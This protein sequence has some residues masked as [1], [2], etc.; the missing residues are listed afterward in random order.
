MDKIKARRLAFRLLVALFMLAGV[1]VALAEVSTDQADYSPGSVVTISGS[2]ADGAGYLPG[3]I[4]DVSVTGPDGVWTA[5]CSALVADDGSWSCQIT[6]SS[7]LAIAVGAYTYTAAGET[8]GT[9][10]YGTF[11]DKPQCN[12]S[13]PTVVSLTTPVAGEIDVS[14]TASTADYGT[15]TYRV[16]YINGGTTIT[17]EPVAG[18]S[19]SA[20]GLAAGSW[21]VKIQAST[22]GDCAN[23]QTAD[24]TLGTIDVAAAPSGPTADA[25]GPYSGDE[26]TG[27]ALDATAS[28][29]TGTLHYSW[30]VDYTGIDAGG[31]CSFDDPTSATPVVTCDDDDNGSP[32]TV[33][34]EVT[35]DNG[36]DSDSA[37]LSVGN[38]DPVV[39]ASD[40]WTVTPSNCSLD[41]VV[42]FSDDGAN[43]T[44]T[45][46]IDW[47]DGNTTAGVV[48]GVLG[49]VSG[50]HAYAGPGTYTITVEVTDDDG[51]VGDATLTGFDNT[52]E[53]TYPIP[54]I[55][56]DKTFKVGSAIPIKVVVDGCT[57]GLTPQVVITP[58]NGTVS[59]KG[60]SNLED[61]MRYTAALPGFIYNWDTKGWAP[62]TTYTVTVT[63]LPGSIEITSTLYLK[64]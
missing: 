60:R 17:H 26:G 28:T 50:S 40:D 37:D 4:V 10:E 41:V 30:T 62:N 61:Y 45:A 16:K 43:D 23:G 21:Q 25:G 64:K 8:S 36:T 15:V 1:T 3:E 59:S 31:S 49:T 34:V 57:A 39:D 12:V 20:T 52:P 46:T 18:T 32:F 14:W 9:V 2:S 58:A 44:H 22:D 47:G 19:D 29:G 51:G 35:D 7:D 56:P 54:P 5:E 24:I 11:T 27:I 38:V 63:G 53:L 6:L 33:T 42:G 13:D 55:M 48:D